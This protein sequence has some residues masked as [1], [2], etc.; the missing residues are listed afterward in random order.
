MISN[1]YIITADRFLQPRYSI[2]PFMTNC[3]SSNRHLNDSDKIDSYLEE[4][5]KN[6][7]YVFTSSG[8]SSLNQALSLLNLQKNDI[9]TIF[10]TTGNF[11]I[12]GCVTGEIE[13]YCLW[14]RK[15]EKNTKVILV[16]HEFGFPYERLS[17]LLNYNLPIIEDCAHSFLSQNH[18]KT[19]GNIGMYIIYSLPKF[20]PLQFGG[21][22]VSNGNSDIEKN[23]SNEEERYI[24]NVLSDHI[25]DINEIKQKRIVNYKYLEEKLSKY[26]FVP[27]FDLCEDIHC[28]GVY[29][30]KV[31]QDI[32]LDSMKKF[33]QSHGVECSVFYRETAFFLPVHQGLSFDD[34]D[35]FV[36][37][38]DCF[39][40]QA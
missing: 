37:L 9:V 21:I 14:S 40:K 33:L 11:Y 13:K 39:M 20:F 5:F 35:Y 34:L 16:N 7:K 23:I 28:P 29:L 1:K 18:E 6:R 24:K 26:G 22:L 25:T 32:G 2:S 12:S 27:R 10:T 19:V 3:V 30:F 17:E 4:R 38:I 8:R 31:N 15:L 36:T